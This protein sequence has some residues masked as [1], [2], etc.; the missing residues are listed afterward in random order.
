MRHLSQKMVP[1]ERQCFAPEKERK[2]TWQA[3]LWRLDR[4]F[5]F[6]GC[7]IRYFSYD[8]S[9][10]HEWLFPRYLLAIHHGGA[11]I[12]TV[13]FPVLG[14]QP[15]WDCVAVLGVGPREPVP[16]EKLFTSRMVTV[17]LWRGSKPPS[18]QIAALASPSTGFPMLTF[19]NVLAMQSHIPQENAEIFQ[20][21]FQVSHDS[22]GKKYI[23]VSKSDPWNLSNVFSDC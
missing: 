1:Q 16:L 12:P 9:A 17:T 15:F 3:V 8:Q 14:D 13:I 10:P 22:W 5:C 4:S 20:E 23:R 19:H 11:G 21:L 2:G 7:T 18:R 6:L